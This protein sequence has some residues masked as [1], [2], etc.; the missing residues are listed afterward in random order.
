MLKLPTTSYHAA[1]QE[2]IHSNDHFKHPSLTHCQHQVGF[3]LLVYI[4]DVGCLKKIHQPSVGH[5][6][7]YSH[8]LVMAYNTAP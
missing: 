8:T 5:L 1:E 3:L 7:Y 2:A 4:T 6:L